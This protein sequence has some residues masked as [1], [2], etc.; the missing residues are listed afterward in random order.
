MV[1]FGPLTVEIGSGVWGTPPNFNG[2]AP[3]AL[4]SSVSYL[5]ICYKEFTP[6]IA[7]NS[8]AKYADDTYLIVPAINADIRSS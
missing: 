1:N 5:Y 6:V 7:G 3:L 8:L 4:S 2:S